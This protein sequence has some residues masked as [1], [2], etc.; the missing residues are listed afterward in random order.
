MESSGRIRMDCTVVCCVCGGGWLQLVSKGG[1]W[2]AAG[3]AGTRARIGREHITHT[4]RLIIGYLSADKRKQQQR[5]QLNMD[6]ASD[7]K[8]CEARRGS[9][10]ASRVGEPPTVGRTL[11]LAHTPTQRH[12]PT[13]LAHPPACQPA[14]VDMKNSLEPIKICAS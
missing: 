8:Q 5:Q 9:T 2:Q 7:T 10:R 13:P 11:P 4:L 12:T 3:G 1:R 14:T 6:E